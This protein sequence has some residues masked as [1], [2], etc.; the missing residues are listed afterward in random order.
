MSRFM[1]ARSELYEKAVRAL[2]DLV[3]R[4]GF[5]DAG[6]AWAEVASPLV[7]R[8]FC[9]HWRVRPAPNVTNCAGRLAGRRHK[10]PFYVCDHCS[11]PGTDHPWLF[12]RDGKPALFV[13]QPY[14]LSWDEMQRLVDW[15][16]ERGLRVDLSADES[17]HFPGRTLAVRIARSEALREDRILAGAAPDLGG[18][19]AA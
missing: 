3:R 14:T 5:D 19:E 4:E 11:P 16:R 6:R 10:P 12:L 9:D 17:W 18:G 1:S 7:R 15:C 13:S 8:R 2:A